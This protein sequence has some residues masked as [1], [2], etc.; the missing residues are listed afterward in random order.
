MKN[1]PTRSEIKKTR[2]FVKEATPTL[3]KWVK[4]FLS[5]GGV[6][7]GPYRGGPFSKRRW[8]REGVFCKDSK[9]RFMVTNRLL[10]LAFD[11]KM[12]NATILFDLSII[13]ARKK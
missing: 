6:K 5:E 12:H 2:A 1:F 11:K 4:K 10:S 13:P 3:L 7:E 8:I 9:G